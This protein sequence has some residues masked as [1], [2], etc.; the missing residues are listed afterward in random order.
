M[1][2][3]TS[4]KARLGI[5]TAVLVGGGAI[6]IAAVASG[7]HSTTS[8]QQSAYG[9]TMNFGHSVSEGA[10]LSAALNQWRWSHE[11]AI[12]TLAHMQSMHT[13]GQ[14]FFNHTTFAAQRGVVLLATP[15]FLLVQDANGSNL[16]AWWL[17]G[18]A[19]SNVSNNPVG[20]IA[21]TGSN[22]AAFQ[23]MTHNTMT[24]VV[25]TMVG[26]TTVNQMTAPVSH[27]TTVT[28]STGTTTISVTITQTSATTTTWQNH[29]T[30]FRSSQPVF[31]HMNGVARGDLVLIS[32]VR[33]FGQLQAK[34]VLFAAPTTT[35]TPTP[36]PT[37]T[38]P[39]APSGSNVPGGTISG[40]HT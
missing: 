1:I 29:T 18:T 33:T 6:G 31:T 26:T 24:P 9:Y 40:S 19:F 21:L 34:L 27:P 23:A 25:N 3:R 36:V 4:M 20:L 2:G 10:A 14:T 16:H 38:T 15:Q 5:A 8:T 13:F 37:S 7:S 39:T 17:R 28:V 30:P 22:W 32:G 12:N 11:S 35:T